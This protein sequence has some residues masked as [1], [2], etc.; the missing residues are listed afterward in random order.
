MPL[1]SVARPSVTIT[2]VSTG[3]RSTG[4]MTMRWISTPPAKAMMS[5]TGSAIQ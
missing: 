4:R 2:S 3:A 5:V 1:T